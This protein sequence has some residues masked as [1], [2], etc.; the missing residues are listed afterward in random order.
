VVENGNS[1][2]ALKVM[3]LVYKIYCADGRWQEAFNI[4]LP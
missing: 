4:Q 2:E 1:A 3:E